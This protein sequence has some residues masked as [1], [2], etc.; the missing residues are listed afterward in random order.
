MALSS[1]PELAQSRIQLQN[2]ELTIRGSRNSL[3]PT[4][5]VVANFSN[6]A[7]AGDPNTLPALAGSRTPTIPF[8]S[9]D[10]ARC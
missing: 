5:D 4:L 8:S 3:L 1:R 9:A 2:Q 6:G 10:T 7:L